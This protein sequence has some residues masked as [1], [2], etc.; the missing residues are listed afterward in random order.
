MAIPLSIPPI[1]R[2]RATENKVDRVR[3]VY[4]SGGQEIKG[5]MVHWDGH[6]RQFILCKSVTNQTQ[7]RCCDVLGKARERFA[8]VVAHYHTNESGFVFAPLQ[9]DLKLWLFGG[10][11]FRDLCGCQVIGRDFFIRCLDQDFQQLSFEACE[12]NLWNSEMD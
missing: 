4:T 10:R 9:Y 8:A 12:L 1:V 3:I 11:I 6:S 2:Y 5:A 7:A